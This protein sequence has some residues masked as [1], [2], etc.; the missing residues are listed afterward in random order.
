MVRLLFQAEGLVVLAGDRGVYGILGRCTATWRCP[1]NS[2][3]SIGR[4]SQ[5]AS[6]VP[7]GNGACNRYRLNK[8]VR[9]ELK[10]A[11]QVAVQSSKRTCRTLPKTVCTAELFRWCG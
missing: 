8:T 9:N 11:F 6:A 2:W 4:S 10:T 1:A 3:L 5:G 7:T